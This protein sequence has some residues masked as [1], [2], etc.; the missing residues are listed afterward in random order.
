MR[1][2]QGLLCALLKEVDGADEPLKPPQQQAASVMALAL[3]GLSCSGAGVGGAG[4]GFVRLP[5]RRLVLVQTGEQVTVMP[6]LG[7]YYSEEA[8][9]VPALMRH[10]LAS[11][12]AVFSSMV[13]LTVRFVPVP[14]VD[15]GERLLVRRC[16]GRAA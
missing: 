1:C 5:R 4:G 15:K 7:V 10:M 14:T 13:F 9:G 2:L 12:P 8:A 6:G 3:P 16:A 11:L